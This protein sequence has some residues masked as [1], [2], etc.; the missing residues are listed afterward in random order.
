MDKSPYEIL[1]VSESASQDEIKKAYRKKAREN[2]P[3]LNPNDPKAAERMNEV[4]EAYDRLM[5]PEKY[6]AQDKRRAAQQD[7]Q[8]AASGYGSPFGGYGYS[9]SG[10]SSQGSSYGQGSAGQGQGYQ[11]GE[12]SYGWSSETFTWDDI[13]GFGFAGS[14]GS[15]RN[16]HPEASASDSS[17]VRTA[18]QYINSGQYKQAAAILSNIPSTGRNARWYYLSA[19]ANYCAGSEMLG[20]EQIR[21]ACQMDP[22]NMEYRRAMQAFQQPSQTYAQESQQRGFTMGTSSCLECCC[23]LVLINVCLNSCL[24]MGAYSGG[25]NMGMGGGGIY[26]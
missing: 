2:H 23:G 10:G 3:D 22:N 6:E 4:N 25:M 18:I 24:R 5:N 13:F 12:G 8:N 21:R 16:I 1:G 7:S 9:G 26:C 20:Y 19:I 17:E 14:A 15:P 11:S